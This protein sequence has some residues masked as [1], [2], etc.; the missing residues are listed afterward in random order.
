MAEKLVRDRIPD[1]SK[2][3]GE[4][5]NFRQPKDGNELISFLISKLREETEELIVEIKSRNREKT[6]E[7][8]ADVHTVLMTIM[9]H[10]KL[11][12][13]ELFDRI[14]SKREQKGGFLK[15]VIMEIPE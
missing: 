9:L 2:A 1:L 5:R 12:E 15:S 3:E 13:D 14:E 10:F 7:E 6:I 8:L 4:I 11:T